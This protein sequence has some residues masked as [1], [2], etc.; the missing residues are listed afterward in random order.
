MPLPHQKRAGFQVS[1][2]NRYVI[3]VVLGTVIM[4]L[5]ILAVLPFTQALSGDPRTKDFREVSTANIPP[6][7]PPPPEPPPPPEEEEPEEQPEL[8]QEQQM[9]DLSQLES[10]LNPGVGGAFSGAFD[11]DSFG[12]NPDAAGDMKIFDIED[13]DR[14]PRMTKMV[15]PQYPPELRAE[16]VEG[17]VTLALII[18]EEG[19]VTVDRVLDWEGDRDFIQPTRQALSNC[20]F[21]P[22]TKNG[23]T[24]V[25]RY[26]IT[27]P[28]QL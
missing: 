12:V 13:L 10:A 22:P 23:E 26:K 6:P 7:E 1:R 28:F 11:L 2:S 25:A 17:S 16:G 5:A 15:K 24:V 4:T 19:R 14:R 18:D 8:Q 3:R 9:L 21:E 27:I 20:R